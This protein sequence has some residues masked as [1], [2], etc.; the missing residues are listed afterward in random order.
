MV[1]AFPSFKEVVLAIQDVGIP[2]KKKQSKL[3]YPVMRGLAK[4]IYLHVVDNKDEFPDVVFPSNMTRAYD[5]IEGLLQL[6]RKQF[7][8]SR[9]RP[10]VQCVLEDALE[11]GKQLPPM[12]FLFTNESDAGIPVFKNRINLKFK[13]EAAVRHSNRTANDALRVAGILLLPSNRSS[14]AGIPKQ[15]NRTKC[16]QPVS[17]TVAFS[18]KIETDFHD[19]SLVITHPQKLELLDDWE[20][21]DPN[22]VDRIEVQGRNAAWV[23]GT[24]LTYIKP[25]Y[26]KA[27]MNWNK[28]TGGGS[29]E[30]EAF[31]NYCGSFSWLG[32]IYLKDEE[33]GFLLAA[34]SDHFVPSI[35]SNESGFSNGIGGV[36]DKSD[37]KPA[38]SKLTKAEKR[39]NTVMTEAMTKLAKAR[40]ESTDFLAG[41]QKSMALVQKRVADEETPIS[42]HMKRMK[43]LDSRYEE[44]ETKYGRLVSANDLQKLLEGIDA[45]RAGLMKSIVEIQSRRRSSTTDVELSILD[46]DSDTSESDIY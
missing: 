30:S 46:S 23:W 31:Q 22:D 19:A 4:A 35:L 8:T 40:E 11:E 45:E 27:L 15:K 2:D 5:L 12:V 42:K 20:S 6:A 24:W 41:L 3:V 18:E 10:E 43:V 28:R 44:Y 38:T 14:F 32:W 1:V 17:T 34:C 21:F 7:D 26:A 13:K 9:I 16:D 29:G 33:S 36:D 25:K 39:S 37:S